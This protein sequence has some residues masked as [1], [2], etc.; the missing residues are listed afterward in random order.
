MARGR[1]PAAPAAPAAPLQA[2]PAS[3]FRAR[4]SAGQLVE[5]PSGLVARLRMAPIVATVARLGYVPNPLSED[6]LRELVVPPPADESEA[7][8]VAGYQRYQKTQVELAALK[9][10]EPRLVLD[11]APDYDAG[12]I[13]VCDLSDQDIRFVAGWVEDPAALPTFRDR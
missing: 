4:H 5:L 9:L 11:R 1:T 3:A 10:V 12:E 13:G 6:V 8:Q 2:S 7:Q